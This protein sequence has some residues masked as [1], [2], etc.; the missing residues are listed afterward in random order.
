MKLSLCLLFALLSSGAAWPAPTPVAV[1][2]TITVTPPTPQP[3]PIQVSQTVTI[4][5]QQYT[6]TGLLTATPV[7]TTAALP[8]GGGNPIP[9]ALAAQPYGGTLPMLA[10][11]KNAQQQW[12]TKFLPGEAL[13]VEGRGFGDTTGLVTLGTTLVAP[14]EWFDDEVGIVVPVGFA[15]Q[16]LG[17]TLDVR[18]PSGAHLT[19]MGPIIGSK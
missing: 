11:F 5:G 2:L 10:G 17:M 1:P 15:P 6:I 3:I 9:A 4:A 14:T 19:D 18:L 8:A 13:F 7:V 16:P 12:A